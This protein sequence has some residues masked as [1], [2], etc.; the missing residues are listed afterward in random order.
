MTWW[1]LQSPSR[2]L[3]RASVLTMVLVL[4]VAATENPAPSMAQNDAD[5]VDISVQ[6]ELQAT[7][8]QGTG[9][10]ASAGQN[11]I[12]PSTSVSTTIVLAASE[13]IGGYYRGDSQW[14]GRPWAAL[15]GAQSQYPSASIAVVIDQTPSDKVVVTLTGLNDETGI[16]N[17]INVTLNGRSLFNGASWFAS[18]DG[19]GQG[20]NAQWTTVTMRIPASYFTVGTNTLT[21]QNLRQGS[22]FS[23]P[24]YVLLGAASI[25]VPGSSASIGSP[26]GVD[27]SVDN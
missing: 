3:K 23:E 12:D 18:W 26:S 22:N 25:E 27:I 8:G 10:A 11:L 1:G 13:W 24:P 2:L 7:G 20:Q 4:M 19:Q 6:G 21:I 14:Y 17:N 15:Y 16:K 9:A 5:S